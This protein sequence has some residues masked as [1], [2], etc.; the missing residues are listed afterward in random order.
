MFTISRKG[1]IN[2]NCRISQERRL[3]LCEINDLHFERE[4]GIGRDGIACALCSVGVMRW[5]RK[6][7]FL[8][9]LKLSDALIPTADDL[10]F[11]NF[12]F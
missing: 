5:A 1:E 9:L 7:G 10:A 8:A 4:G 2:L 12:K 3:S 11:A 6:D